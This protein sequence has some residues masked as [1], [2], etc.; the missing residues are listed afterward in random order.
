MY[1]QRGYSGRMRDGRMQCSTDSPGNTGA[2]YANTARGTRWRNNAEF[3]S[4]GTFTAKYTIACGEEILI[5]YDG[6]SEK[7]TYWDV[8]GKRT[9]IGVDGDAGG[10]PSP[11]P[12]PQPPPQVRH[13]D[14]RS[15]CSGAKRSG[16]DRAIRRGRVNAVRARASASVISALARRV[17]RFER[18]EGGGVT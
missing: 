2:Q 14:G 16:N 17:N 11:S 5:D 18:G 8:W 7:G 13:G 3:G 10:T 6:N 15:D 1:V 9:G 12:P 4:T